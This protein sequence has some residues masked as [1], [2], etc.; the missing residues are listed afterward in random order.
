MGFP[1]YQ[2]ASE[3]APIREDQHDFLVVGFTHAT[4]NSLN[5]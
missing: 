5:L 1:L 4:R 3:Q 2:P